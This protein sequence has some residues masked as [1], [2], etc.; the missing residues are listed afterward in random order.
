MN[1]QAH[2]QHIV[3]RLKAIRFKLKLV[4][5]IERSLLFFTL[6]C[7]ILFVTPAA[8]WIGGRDMVFRWLFFLSVWAAI[9]YFGIRFFARPLASAL[10]RRHSPSLDRIALWIGQKFED[11]KDE[12]GNVLQIV[13]ET[14]RDSGLS[15]EMA[16]AAF[17]RVAERVERLPL[18]QII[19]WR[20]AAVHAV[21]FALTLTLFWAGLQLFPNPYQ[22]ALMMLIAPHRIP[23]QERF[24]VEVEPGSVEMI[25]GEALTIRA[26]FSD[27]EVER[28]GLVT[29]DAATGVKD[30]IPL[31]SRRPGEYVY[32]FDHVTS[33]FSYQIVSDR[34]QSPIYQVTVVQVPDIRELQLTV[35]P[36]KYTHLPEQKLDPNIGNIR[37]LPGTRVTVQVL[38]TK[39]IET[40]ALVFGDADTLFMH[41]EG[42]TYRTAFTV[43]KEREYRIVVQDHRGLVNPNPIVYQIKLTADQVP[44]VDIPFPGR[45][46]D[47]D[48]SMHVVLGIVGEDD[49]G[50]SRLWLRYTVYRGGPYPSQEEGK[51]KIPFKL[52]AGK[53][54]AE[55][56]WDLTTLSLLPEDVVEYYAEAFD[57]D[58]VS[59]PKR[60]LSAIYRLR[61]PS[62]QEIFAEAEL[63]QEEAEETVYEMLERS[64]EIRERVS[65]MLQELRRE[66]E[67][68]WEER[69]KLKEKSEQQAEMLRE[70]EA[71]EQKLDEMID[72]LEKNDL[73]T[74]ETLKKYQELQ[75]LLQE[76]ATPELRKMMEKLK[77]AL[78]NLDPR[79]VQKALEEF[80]FSQEEFLKS[81]EKTINMLK[82]LKAEQKLEEAIRSVEEMLERQKE[83]NERLDKTQEKAEDLA[84]QQEQQQERLDDLQQN[85]EQLQQQIQ[86]LPRLQIP[87]EP[88]QQAKNLAESRQLRKDIQ[89]ASQSMQRGQMQQARQSARQVE[90]RLRQMQDLLSGAQQQMQQNQRA[91]LMRQLR[92][93][94]RN[95]LELS[96]REER[97]ARETRKLS[98]SSPKYRNLADRQQNLLSA[99]QRVTEQLFQLSQ[100]SFFVPPEIGRKLGQSLNQMQQAIRELEQRRSQQASRAQSKA[101]QALNGAVAELRNTMKNLSGQSTGSSLEQMMQR[102]MGISGEQRG[103]NQQTRSL[104]ESGQLS[105]E[106]QAA[107]S[108]LAAQQEAL[109]KSLEQLQREFG[110]RSEIL[111]SLDQIARDMEKVAQEMRQKRVSREMI[112]RQQRILSRL[113]DAQK[114]VHKREYSKKRKAETGKTYLGLDPGKLPQDLGES[115]FKI[116]QDLLRALKE[117]YSKDY[118]LLIQKYFEALNK[119]LNRNGAQN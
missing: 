102:L 103:I 91:E 79:Q 25:R 81:L 90:N 117:N 31:F 39:E 52:Q 64:R 56:D 77:E 74:L 101:M 89:Q 92:K 87:S 53:L 73:L 23:D 1:D 49:F 88:I 57:N 30:Q 115:R 15:S 85:L 110:N 29:I 33:S 116:Q 82:Q 21:A 44:V 69:Q 46:I 4:T 67:L 41:P 119:E 20:K 76:V 107:L 10:F 13:R 75:Q 97:L 111:G 86:E 66:P 95:L 114:S 37:V 84:R 80:Q 9:F 108:R 22:Q 19:T 96:K 104:G 11:I 42:R 70:L 34:V 27:P 83:I 2:Y 98:P 48:E 3:R 28:V 100:N 43:K 62:I 63:Q 38:P 68:D 40:A 6:L 12:L 94:S 50:F 35:K 17:R 61:F 71:V 105:L 109:R 24:Q 8:S 60:A 7:A 16:W 55:F 36:P 18:E 51:I 118:K 5:F 59:G 112:Q 47:I 45:D 113:L 32:R 14:S 65:E 78:E 26:R 72:R 99:M 58:F 106:Q 93:G 54:Q